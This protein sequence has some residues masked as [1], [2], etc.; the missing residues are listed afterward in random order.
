M[1]NVVIKLQKE[2][3]GR[4]EVKGFHFTQL[5]RGLKACIY[6]VADSGRLHYEVFKIKIGKIPKSNE[7]YEPYPKANSFG[8]WAWT[9]QNYENAIERFEIIEIIENEK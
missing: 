1:D 7:L 2:F 3:I 6:E 8:I 5:K 4:G 9:F